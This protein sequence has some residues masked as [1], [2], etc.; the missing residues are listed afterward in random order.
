MVAGS[1][2]RIRQLNLDSVRT[3]Q[4]EL[5][6]KLISEGQDTFVYDA[7]SDVLARRMTAATMR[8]ARTTF[9]GTLQSIRL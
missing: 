5:D 6:R 7:P 2:Y 9:P 8:N 4:F 1:P 3:T